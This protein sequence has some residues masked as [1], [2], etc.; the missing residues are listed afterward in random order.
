MA[1]WIIH[2]MDTNANG[3]VLRARYRVEGPDTQNYQCHAEEQAFEPSDSFTP[4]NELTEA[5][6]VGW[7]KTLLGPEQVQEIERRVDEKLIYI[8][9]FE[10]P[11][12]PWIS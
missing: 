4:Y 11:A 8:P 6:V 1:I 12:L 10:N 2:Q 3:L 5:Q 7:I 9:P